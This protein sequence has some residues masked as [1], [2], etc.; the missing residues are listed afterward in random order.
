[1]AFTPNSRVYLLDTPLDN[2]YKNE[3]RFT[4]RADQYN[5]FMG[6]MKHTFEG[7]TYQRKNN[8]IRVDAHLDDLWNVNYVMYQNTNFDTKW[9][10]AFITKMEYVS[11]RATD[12]F[13]ETDV[14]Q[15][16]FFEF[17]IK[18]CFVVREHVDDDTIG[19]HLVDEQLETGE[20]IMETNDPLNHFGKEYFILAVSDNSP[21]GSTALVGN[22]YA[23]VPTGL[24]YWLF[25]NNSTGITWLKNTI[26]AYTD[27]G[28]AD[29]IVMLFVVPE[30]IVKSVVDDPSFDFGE[31]I[32]SQTFYGYDYI[33]KT[34]RLTDL[35]GYVPRNNKMFIYPYKF[36]Y[37]SNG[38]GGSAVYRYEYFNETNPAEMNFSL[39]GGIMPDPKIIL[40]PNNYKGEGFYE[41]GLTLQG[42][43]LGSWTT[44]TYAAWL[45]SNGASTA[46]NLIG[47]AT[48]LVGGIATGGL[49]LLA[50]GGGAV[51]IANQ[52]AQIHQASIQPDQAK[53]QVG[54]GNLLFATGMLD[55]Y[56]SHMSIKA[57]YAKRIDDFFTMFG[58]KV[59]TLKV[60]N[61][62]S[63]LNWNYIQTID[64][65][66]T[67]AIPADDMVKLK[68]IF[69]DG[70]TFWHNPD[71]FLDYSQP[72]PI[73]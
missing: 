29:A 6:R 46:V 38:S 73:I 63:R 27:A 15:T 8:V 39:V 30:F 12:I 14:Y 52:L 69:N 47:S 35:D 62:H 41:Y 32:P 11:D 40:T 66:L 2:T 34:K 72:N 5:Y 55:F 3:L 36:L 67:G 70:I 42:F 54:N 17:G 25:E 68:K 48:L 4:T 23:H 10:Y 33:T 64:A 60:P 59:N 56:L 28:K 1:M 61:V 24:S 31:P 53:G 9:F 13:I 21:L 7:V 45:A 50:A 71:T 51:N 26:K 16:W 58:Y 44:D 37:V 18:E 20:H 19:K 57:E 65:N 22:I 49:G 43:P